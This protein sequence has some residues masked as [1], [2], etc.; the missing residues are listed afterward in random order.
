MSSHSHLKEMKCS[1]CPTV[2]PVDRA[3]IACQCQPCIQ[4]DRP[5]PRVHH[6]E[7]EQLE[8]G[9]EAVS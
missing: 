4:N 6:E 8:L 1:T 2:M 3:A 5:R 7:G 9:Q